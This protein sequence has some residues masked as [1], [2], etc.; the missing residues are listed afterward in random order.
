MAPTAKSMAPPMAGGAPSD[1]PVFQLARSPEADTSNAPSTA[2][3]ICPPRI[4]ANAMLESK[5][6]PPVLIVTGL[7]PALIR[8]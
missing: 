2:T 1:F 7:L 8:S 3:S 4:I 5:K 6:A